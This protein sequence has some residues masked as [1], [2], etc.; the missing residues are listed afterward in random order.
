MDSFLESAIE[1][2]KVGLA[3]GGVPIGSVLVYKNEIIFLLEK[4]LGD[5]Y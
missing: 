5:V 3:E 4:W 2:A 1:E